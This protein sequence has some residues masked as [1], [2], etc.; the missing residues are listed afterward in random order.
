M[1]QNQWV[2]LGVLILGTILTFFGAKHGAS[3]GSKK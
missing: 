2:E 3:R 1:S